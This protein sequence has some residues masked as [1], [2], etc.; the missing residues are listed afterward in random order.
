M[1]LRLPVPP[2]VNHYFQ[3]NKNGSMRISEDGL[4]FRD[5]VMVRVIKRY[6]KPKTIHGRVF[7]EIQIA[8]KDYVRRDLDNVLKAL[9]D[10]LEHAGIYQND[11]QIDELIIVRLPVEKPGRCDVR[12][13][14]INESG[15]TDE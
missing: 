8:F 2:S 1:K 15:E 12:I 6:G 10:G 5:E 7:V 11:S 13:L 14:E 3:R 4:R 9:L